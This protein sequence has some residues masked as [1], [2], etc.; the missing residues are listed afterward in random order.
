MH[1]AFM[2]TDPGSCDGLAAVALLLLAAAAAVGVGFVWGMWYGVSRHLS[3]AGA[4]RTAA[5]ATGLACALV[6]PLLVAT[7]ARSG[8]FAFDPAIWLVVLAPPAAIAFGVWTLLG[9]R[10]RRRPSAV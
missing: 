10:A 6:P 5:N 8:L 7:F 3:R 9:E 4:S 1:P 2:C